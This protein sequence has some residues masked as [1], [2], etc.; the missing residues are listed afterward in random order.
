MTSAPTSNR[1]FPDTPVF[2]GYAAP[3]RVEGEVFDLDVEGRIP[4]E[5][6]GFYIRNSAD[7]QF[8]PMFDDDLFLN[9]DG[10]LHRIAIAGGRAD[11]KTRYVET[12]K[13]KRERG[14]RRALFGKYR[15]MFTDDPSVE[16]VER[17]TANT[18][19]SWHGGGCSRSRRRRRRRESIR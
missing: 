5:L 14:A 13:Y 16:G 19:V 15:N 18:S 1:P 3:V 7:H 4:P 8:A 12:E 9:G 17:T 6:D 10:M 2:T 11:L